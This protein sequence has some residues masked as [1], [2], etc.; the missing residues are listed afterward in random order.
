MQTITIASL[1]GGLTLPGMIDEPGSFSGRSS[2]PRPQRGPEASQRISFAN[3]INATANPRSAPI[4][5]TIAS[6]EPWAANLFG[7]VTNGYPVSSAI[8]AA[9]SRLQFGGGVQPG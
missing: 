8:F 6:S 7:A 4:A 1:W 9:I 2:S 5:A 3:F